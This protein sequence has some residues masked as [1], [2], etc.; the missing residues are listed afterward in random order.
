MNLSDERCRAVPWRWG[1]HLPYRTPP[2][3]I[4]RV[5]R[6][7]G[8]RSPQLASGCLRPGDRWDL[9]PDRPHAEYWEFESCASLWILCWFLS[10]CFFNWNNSVRKFNNSYRSIFP[11][12]SVQ[13]IGRFRQNVNDLLSMMG[14]RWVILQSWQNT[15]CFYI[16]NSK[17]ILQFSVVH[18]NNYFI[19][20]LYSI[21]WSVDGSELINWKKMIFWIGIYRYVN[22]GR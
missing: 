18:Y 8:A 13:Y 12:F 21:A 16:Y 9:W 15:L 14:R 3:L 10:H 19:L 20:L 22:F 11:C 17:L 7:T 6:V 1:V 5:W 2:V 4:I